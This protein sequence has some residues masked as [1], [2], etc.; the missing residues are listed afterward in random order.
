M[1]PR[2][3]ASEGEGISIKAV[4][5]MPTSTVTL[6]RAHHALLVIRVVV[7]QLAVKRKDHSGTEPVYRYKQ[8]LRSRVYYLFVCTVRSRGLS[9]FQRSD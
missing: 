4:A 9:P 8:G 5:M 7:V 6:V 1:I 3:A 2:R